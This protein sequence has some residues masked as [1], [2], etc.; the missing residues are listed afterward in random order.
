M[1]RA[2]HIITGLFWVVLGPEAAI[3]ER[4]GGLGCG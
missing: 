3:F 4:H 2:R 1:L